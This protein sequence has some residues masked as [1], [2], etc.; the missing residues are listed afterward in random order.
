MLQAN[1]TV[2][3]PPGFEPGTFQFVRLSALSIEL[4][5]PQFVKALP[6]RLRR[7]ECLRLLHFNPA[8]HLGPF[9]SP[10]HAFRPLYQVCL[11]GLLPNHI[12]MLTDVGR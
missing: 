11:S 1:C 10:A 5:R 7:R 4:R 2:E 8:M 9:V 3:P 6:P 12:L